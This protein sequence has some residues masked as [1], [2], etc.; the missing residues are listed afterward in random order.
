MFDQEPEGDP[1]GECA[2]EIS[3]LTKKLNEAVTM[4]AEWCV[5]VADNGAGWD[6]WDEHYKDACYRPCGLREMIDAKMAA[7]RERDKPNASDQATASK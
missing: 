5:A 4:L 7:I 2:A 6:D 1:H 3:S